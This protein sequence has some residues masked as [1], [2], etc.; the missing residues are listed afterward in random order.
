MFKQD[1]P[2]LRDGKVAYL[3][4]AASA[5]KPEVVVSAMDYIM[6]N[7][8]ANIHRGLYGWSQD[9]TQAYENVRAQVAEFIDVENKKEIIFTKNST[10]SINLVAQ[11]WGRTFMKAGDEIIISETEHHANIV[12]WQLLRDQIGIVIKVI[13]IS[14]D[15]KLDISAYTALL[16]EKTK[17]ISIVH[18]SNATG[19]INDMNEVIDIARK[20]NPEIKILVDGSQSVVHQNISMKDIQC[21]F[22]VFTGHKL[23]GPTGIG[24]LWGKEDI[25][26]AMPPY[27]GGG[28]MIETVTFEKT[29]YQKTPARFEAGTPA[30]LEVIGLGAA[31]KYITDIGMDVITRH[32]AEITEYAQEEL[33]KIDGITVLGRNANKVGIFSF[34]MDGAHP[35]DVA[36]IFDQMGVA[37]RTG[38]HCCMPLMQRL[39]I[40]GTIRASIGMYTDKDD[41]DRLI[42]ALKKAQEMLR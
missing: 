40:D 28:D 3:D 30:I 10:E 5:Q 41:I 36:M 37:V 33:D 19:V 34:T 11:S 31:I 15:C 29:I 14:D 23:Y 1:F 2:S 22:F 8:Y 35:S 25:L 9:M 24:V 26:N 20:Y 21:D 13:P 12:P 18:I 16:S 32:E 7:G 38:H 42:T 39:K 27:Q 4:S 6:R 17:F